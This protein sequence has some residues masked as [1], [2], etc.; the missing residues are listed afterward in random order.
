MQNYVVINVSVLAVVFCRQFLKNQ[1][2]C[3]KL[4]V[5]E[6][7]RQNTLTSPETFTEN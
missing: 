4:L 2:F 5:L 1:Q 3:L 7:C 6:N